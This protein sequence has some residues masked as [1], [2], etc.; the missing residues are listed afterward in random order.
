M[1]EKYDIKN[2]NPRPNPYAKLS[3]KQV[4]TNLDGEVVAYIKEQSEKEPKSNKTI[5]EPNAA[6]YAAMDAAEK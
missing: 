5:D 4:T 3:Q 2:L 6:T 1:R